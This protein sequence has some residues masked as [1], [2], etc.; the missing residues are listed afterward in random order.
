VVPFLLKK[1][2]EEYAAKNG[3]KLATYAEVL[4]AVN[5]GQ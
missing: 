5:V 2:A 4:G 1:D 3:G